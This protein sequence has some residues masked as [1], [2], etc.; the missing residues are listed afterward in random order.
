MGFDQEHIVMLPFLA[1][2]HLIPFL[3]L[4]NQIHH[5]TGFTITIATTPLNAQYLRSAAQPN[6]N[7][8]LAELPFPSQ[9]YGLPPNT[10]NTEN[11]P[12]NLIIK[13]GTTTQ[14]LEMPT[15]RL[16]SQITEQQ[17]KPPLGLCNT[18]NLY[19]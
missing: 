16:L 19:I 15:R 3:A 1:L 17:G 6:S 13:L 18:P 12:L 5:R 11:L 2:G 7:I 10:E 14:H 9:D 8:H 4:A